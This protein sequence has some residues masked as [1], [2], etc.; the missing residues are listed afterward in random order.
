M[1]RE[2]LT[3]DEA[4]QPLSIALEDD[5]EDEAESP[6]EPSESVELEE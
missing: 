3:L 1:R 6:I 5:I 4:L 2:G